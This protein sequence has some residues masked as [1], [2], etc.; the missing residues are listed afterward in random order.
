MNRGLEEEG[1][2]LQVDVPLALQSP[3]LMARGAAGRGPEWNHQKQEAAKY[4]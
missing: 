3:H 2:E 1:C 4:G